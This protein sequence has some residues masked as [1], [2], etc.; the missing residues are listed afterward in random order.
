MSAVSDIKLLGWILDKIATYSDKHK[1][2]VN[3]AISAIHAAW[4]RTY[5][6]LRNQSGD[7]IPN[8]ELSDLWNEAAQK[9]RLVNPELASQLQDKSRFWIHPGLPR[10]RR[11]LLLTEI[12]DELERLNKKFE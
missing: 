8:Q 4:T 2:R 1:E 5:D 7:Y 10:Q 9:T 3:E 12:V 6:Y 11:I